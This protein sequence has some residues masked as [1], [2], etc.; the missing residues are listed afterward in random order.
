MTNK[1]L[2]WTSSSDSRVDCRTSP[3]TPS[4]I[5]SGTIID[6]DS[7]DKE[8][9]RGRHRE[10]RQ[11]HAHEHEHQRRREQR[12]Q[13]VKERSDTGKVIEKQRTKSYHSRHHIHNR[14]YA[15][16]SSRSSS[17]SCSTS[18]SSLSYSS[19]SS[20]SSS[21]STTDS[22]SSND[23]E[24]DDNCNYNSLTDDDDKE[25]SPDAYVKQIYK[26]RPPRIDT[27]RKQYQAAVPESVTE[28]KVCTEDNPLDQW[29]P[30]RV[31]Y[32]YS[33]P[34]DE[35]VAAWTA[36]RLSRKR[37]RSPTRHILA[38]PLISTHTLAA[39][40]PCLRVT[41]KLSPQTTDIDVPSPTSS[42]SHYDRHHPLVF[43]NARS[44][45]LSP[46]PIHSP[47]APSPPSPP[48]FACAQ[49][50]NIHKISVHKPTRRSQRFAASVSSEH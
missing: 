37:V 12:Q 47:V 22:D 29:T 28:T 40:V 8:R 30:V 41:S 34:T 38:Q 32:N 14:T 6:T 18:S 11:S 45:T 19:S 26:W 1:R 23:S 2:R 35:Q 25:E 17:S 9:E 16:E 43:V 50:R 33:S 10:Q 4:Q 7:D 21:S 5:S 31:H 24:N 20:S 46:P 39:V 49:K 3:V 36:L 48:L 13:Q 42:P 15:P 27:R 44:S